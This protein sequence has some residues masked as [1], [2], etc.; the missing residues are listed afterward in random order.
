MD[1]KNFL[2]DIKLYGLIGMMVLGLGSVST[3]D[4]LRQI[5]GTVMTSDISI[6]LTGILVQV[7]TP[8]GG[9]YRGI[10][11]E[12]AWSLLVQSQ[13]GDA[14]MSWQI[15]R[16]GL[17]VTYAVWNSSSGQYTSMVSPTGV[18]VTW[19]AL[20]NTLHPP[21]AW[22]SSQSNQAPIAGVP[23]APIVVTTPNPYASVYLDASPSYDPDGDLLEY[24][25]DWTDASSGLPVVIFFKQFNATFPKGGTAVTLSVTDGTASASLTFTVIVMSPPGGGGG[26][27]Q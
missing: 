1:Q 4:Q 10:T 9:V 24:R 15:S 12:G 7:V 21:L 18:S 23:Q 14:V 2:E 5:S 19:A 8:Q 6:S 22:V 16:G 13:A 26:G 27:E 17:A 11:N 3:A 25:W 20:S